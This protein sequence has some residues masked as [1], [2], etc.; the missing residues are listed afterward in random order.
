M[1]PERRI[2]AAIAILAIAA[3]I[4]IPLAQLDFAGVIDAFGIDAGDTPSAV[5]VLAG[6]GGVLTTGVLALAAAGVALVLAGSPHAAAVL[7]A[8]ALGGLATAP[9]LWLPTGLL[10]GAAA[11]LTPSGAAA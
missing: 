6:A 3:A 1:T 8:A 5:L 10:L 9:P 11:H 4:P 2:A 7:T